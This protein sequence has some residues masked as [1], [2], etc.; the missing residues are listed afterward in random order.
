MLQTII[1]DDHL[2]AET[3]DA[4]YL[5]HSPRENGEEPAR[6]LLAG[7]FIDRFQLTQKP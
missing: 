6:D 7:H 2:H 5:V 3:L 1:G 4:S